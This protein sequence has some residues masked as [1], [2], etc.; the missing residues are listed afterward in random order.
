[1]A[2]RHGSAWDRAYDVRPR[3]MRGETTRRR[4][5]KPRSDEDPRQGFDLAPARLHPWAVR[6]RP[7]S[8]SGE[9][10]HACD[11]GIVLRRS[12]ASS[13][14]CH[15]A[16]ENAHDDVRR[17]RAISGRPRRVHAQTFVPTWRSRVAT[18][19]A[20]WD[21]LVRK[22]HKQRQTAYMIAAPKAHQRIARHHS[23]SAGHKGGRRPGR[24]GFRLLV[25]G[26]SVQPPKN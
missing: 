18:L 11:R 19:V 23:P 26:R 1:M 5:F 14:R 12:S 16:R 24:E 7:I 22:T 21:R 20:T 25:G 3:R 9:W 10:P 15:R 13:A 4:A 2:A 17:G 8:A 6:S